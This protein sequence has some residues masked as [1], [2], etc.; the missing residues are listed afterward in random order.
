MNAQRHR[1][2]FKQFRYTHPLSFYH[3]FLF[4]AVLARW[5][6]DG[7]PAFVVTGTATFGSAAFLLLVPIRQD[8][9]FKKAVAN[10]IPST[11]L[12]VFV[13]NEADFSE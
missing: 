9:Q 5:V 1:A 13:C 10:S 2:R 3:C 8:T 12:F 4:G 6:V 11:Q 7:P